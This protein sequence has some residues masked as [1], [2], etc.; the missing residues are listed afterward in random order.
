M[1]NARFRYLY[2]DGANYKKWTEVVFFNSSAI[3]VNE[4]T[5]S[6]RNAFLT[7][8][9]FIAHQIRVPE[10]FLVQDYPLSQDDHCYH[11]FD[12]IE[13]TADQ[14][15]DA[16]GRSIQQFVIEVR[17]EAQRGWMAF[18]AQLTPTAER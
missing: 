7:D 9:L 4:V 8:G 17:R 14:P 1:E 2:R 15:T 6:L 5:E 10:V 16:Y 12:S 13:A 18:D 3:S 11:E